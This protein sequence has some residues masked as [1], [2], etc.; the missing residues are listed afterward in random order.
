M[1]TKLVRDTRDRAEGREREILCSQDS[2]PSIC[3]IL[4]AWTLLGKSLK[5][6]ERIG[7]LVSNE[8]ALRPPCIS[9]SG[10]VEIYMP[11]LI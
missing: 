3:G 2:V 8:W 11:L 4:R 1:R 9:P 6:L 7:M 10:W 5:E